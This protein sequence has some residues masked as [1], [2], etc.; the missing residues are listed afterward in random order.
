M[1]MTSPHKKYELLRDPYESELKFFKER[2]DVAGMATED[3]KVI[4]NPYSDVHPEGSDAIYKNESSRLHMRKSKNRPMFKLTD[5]QKEEF[6]DYG[7]EQDRRETIAAR[8]LSGDSSSLESTKE[9]RQYVEKLRKE[10]GSEDIRNRFKNIAKKNTDA[11]ST[12]EWIGRNAA[13]LGARSAELVL[14]LPGNIK[15]QFRKEIGQLY[16]FF[17][18]G[19]IEDEETQPP[20]EGSVHELFMN[21]PGSSELREQVMP[22]VAEKITGDKNF[23]EPRNKKEAKAG[24]LLQDVE[25]FFL[26]GTGAL[27]LAVKLGAPILGNLAQ[28]GAKYLGIGQEKAEKIKLGTM[29]ATTLAGQVNAGRFSSERIQAGKQAV[30]QNATANVSNLATRLQ[31]LMTRLNRGLN[32]PSKSRARQG[33]NDLADQIQGGRMDMHSL[34]DARDHINEWISEAGGWD[35]PGPTRDASIRNLN[36]LKRGVIDTINEN[37]DQRFPQAAENYKT[38]YEAAAVTHRSNAASRFIEKNF[39][40]KT[41]SMGAKLLFPAMAGGAAI[42][43]KTAAVGAGLYPL[44]KTGQ[45]LYRVSKSPTLAKYYSDVISNSLAGNAP[46]MVKSMNKLDYELAKDEKKQ[47]KINPEDLQNFKNKFKK[48]D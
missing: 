43:P 19:S 11:E 16:D 39:G 20:E 9:Q 6:K 40:R 24:E 7:D 12:P 35:V 25:S 22:L 27:R 46:A 1:D 38:G 8:I 33:I 37:L 48:K 47:G 29:F 3:Q 26:P 44:Y 32:V 15:K 34:M 14:G 30:P 18:L 41:A 45:V 36:E 28:E 13:Q 31:P 17:N 2:P 4:F 21:P 5:A 42:I 10:M 23:L